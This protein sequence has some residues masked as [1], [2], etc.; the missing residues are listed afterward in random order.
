MANNHSISIKVL[1]CGL[2]LATLFASCRKDPLTLENPNTTY[3]TSYVHQFQTVWEGID[4]IYVLWERDTVD[5]D[6]RYANYLPVF[7]EFDARGTANPV[8]SAEYLKAWR[9]ATKG[10]LDHHMTIVLYNPNGKYRIAFR[11]ASNSY[12]HATDWQ[13]QSAILKNMPGVTGYVEYYDPNNSYVNSIFCMIPGKTQGKHI[14]YFRL[15]NFAVGQMADS[16]FVGKEAM[17][18]PLKAFYGDEYWKGISNGAA[19]RDD[20]ESIIIDLRGNPGGNLAD[21][22][23]VVGSLLQQHFHWGYSRIKMGLGRLDYSGWTRFDIVCPDNHL[24]A[25]KPVVVLSDIN[26]VSCGEVSTHT[27][28]S[29]PFGTVIGERTYG[30]TCALVPNTDKTFSIFYSGCFGNSNLVPFLGTGEP[31]HPEYFEHYVYSGTY[32]VVTAEYKSLEGVGVQPDIEVL[33]DANAL[34]SGVDNQLNRALQFLRTG[35]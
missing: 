26:T 16:H 7:Q 23:L 18:A 10:L 14:A 24:K 2:V 5:W 21:V 12:S 3:C 9:D 27:I 33:Y 35:N 20:V 29:Q 6:A 1:A 32:D 17:E 30:A 31:T 15:S 34:K 19:S 28:K 8:D 11:P 4:H 25:P 13:A 22:S